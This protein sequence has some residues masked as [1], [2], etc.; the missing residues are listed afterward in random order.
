M[1][2]TVLTVDLVTAAVSVSSTILATS[3]FVPAPTGVVFP[4]AVHVLLAASHMA[5]VPKGSSAR[6]NF[7]YNFFK[8]LLLFL[9]I[10]F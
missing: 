6:E 3:A 1:F 4:L 8:L 2:V 10:V 5:G 9:D 7:G